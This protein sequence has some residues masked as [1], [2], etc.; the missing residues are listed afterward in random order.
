MKLAVLAVAFNILIVSV[1][2]S[3]ELNINQKLIVACYHVD[4]SGV[5]SALRN[6]ADVNGRFGTPE[7]PADPLADP[8]ER[9]SHLGSHRWTPL[10]ALTSSSTYPPP[11]DGVAKT[12]KDK[13]CVR[14]LRAKVTAEE[15]EVRQ[16]NVK[17]I[18]S[19][20]LSHNCD[21]EADDGF[22]A[23]ALFMAVDR[24]DLETVRT[25]LRFQA[26]VDKPTRAYIDGPSG[27]TALH[28]AHDYPEMFQLLLDHGANPKLKDSEGE[29]PQAWR[30]RAASL[31]K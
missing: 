6:G 27:V 26:Q 3:G 1:G 19:I 22:G 10:L 31:G 25:L 15:L 12:A 4:V 30:E 8:W 28:Q 21:I 13:D 9:H 17:S 2:L 5:V 7:L 16:R 11:P 29:T 14:Q 23:T 24:R 20:L 18:L